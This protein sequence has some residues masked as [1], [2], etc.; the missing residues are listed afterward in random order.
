MSKLLNNQKL[1]KR[2]KNKGD[3][4]LAVFVFTLLLL[5][6]YSAM[7][8]SYSSPTVNILLGVSSLFL[9]LVLSDMV[10]K[11]NGYG[12]YAMID[13]QEEPQKKENLENNVEG[14]VTPELEISKEPEN[15]E[16]QP[17]QDYVDFVPDFNVNEVTEEKPNDS[18][19]Q[20]LED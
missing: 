4:V 16:A 18:E 17:K 1:N 2:K 12:K 8:K 7:F 13:K 6:A 14:P 20:Q 15:T 10:D 3:K 9:L 19:Y 5:F 11:L